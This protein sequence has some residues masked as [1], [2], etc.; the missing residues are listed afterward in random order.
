M[1]EGVER[2]E[3]VR[4]VVDEILRLQPDEV[5]SRCGFV[6]LYGVSTAC[7]ILAC[8]RGLDPQL[9]AVAGMLHDI[10]AYKTEP[11]PDHAL[12]GAQEAERI[13]SDLGTFTREQIDLVCDA[14]ACHSDKDRKHSEMAELL[15]DADVLQHYLY[16]P[17]LTPVP[18]G[19]LAR[20]LEELGMGRL[21]VQP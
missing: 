15:K 17:G 13:P 4:R 9:C 10:S 14:I 19:R 16:N 3:S 7:V 8:K 5:Q 12:L 6:H 11:T 1:R 2:L 21:K 18:R 20:V